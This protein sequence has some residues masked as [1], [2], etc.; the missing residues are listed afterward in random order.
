M[1]STE[2]WPRFAQGL[3]QAQNKGRG[4]VASFNLTTVANA[5]WGLKAVRGPRCAQVAVC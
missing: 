3:V 1:F 4:A 5:F 2:D